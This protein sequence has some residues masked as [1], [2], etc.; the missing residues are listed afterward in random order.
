M[1]LSGGLD[2]LRV[3]RVAT[4]LVCPS[5][6]G[7][8]TGIC[9]PQRARPAPA[10]EGVRSATERCWAQPHESGAEGNR[11][12]GYLTW[13]S[14]R[15]LSIQRHRFFGFVFGGWGRA[16][17]LSPP[18]PPTPRRPMEHSIAVLCGDLKATFGAD[19]VY[20]AV[21]QRQNNV[22]WIVAMT[23]WLCHDGI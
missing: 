11:R 20:A 23:L 1:L 8:C 12:C 17:P 10:A 2:C 3:L 13:A 9:V 16:R 19:L 22:L 18:P 7:W 15:W 14:H 5:G 4:S 6:T 21:Q